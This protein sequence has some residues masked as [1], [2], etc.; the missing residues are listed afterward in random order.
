[1]L[2][3]TIKA[4]N[5]SYISKNLEILIKA[6]WFMLITKLENILSVETQEEAWNFA[7][8]STSHQYFAFML[9]ISVIPFQG[10]HSTKYIWKHWPIVVFAL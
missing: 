2:K 9:K 1:M 10:K 5:W 3:V 7:K 6:P 4:Y 8:S